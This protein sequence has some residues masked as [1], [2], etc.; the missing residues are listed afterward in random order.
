[1]SCGFVRLDMHFYPRPPG[2]GRPRAAAGLV[3]CALISIHA[4]RVEGD[5]FIR[6]DAGIISYFYPRPPGGGRRAEGGRTARSSTFLSTPSG[7]RATK[8][9]RSPRRRMRFLSTPSGWRAT[10]RRVVPGWGVVFLSTP[11]GWRATPP[12]P[13]RSRCLQHFYPRPPGGGRPYYFEAAEQRFQFLSTPSG[14]RATAAVAEPA[15]ALAISIHALRVEGDAM[16]NQAFNFVCKFLSTPSG[17]R[18]TY[19]KSISSKQR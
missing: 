2:G 3:G 10:Q 19:T 7:W 6:I 9:R 11:S 17:W 12:A 13:R 8:R 16:L 5:L 14:W 4:L 15:A 18:A 1:M